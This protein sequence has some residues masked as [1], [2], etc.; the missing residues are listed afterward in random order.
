MENTE[1]E[2]KTKLDKK[3]KVITDTGATYNNDRDCRQYSIGS[4]VTELLSRDKKIYNE[5]Q[6]FKLKL[7]RTVAHYFL[8]ISEVRGV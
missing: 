7:M 2:F 3:S 1:G 8:S 4:L 6:I 5:N